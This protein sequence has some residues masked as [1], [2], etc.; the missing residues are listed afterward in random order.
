MGYIKFSHNWNNKLDC[1]IFTTIRDATDK[2][3]YFRSMQG[4]VVDILLNGKRY[5]R[6]KVKLV[7]YGDL[8]QIP[9]DVKVN[10]TGT[11]DYSEIFNKFIKPN[12]QG[13]Q[14]VFL[15]RLERLK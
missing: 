9:E 8:S 5:C 14:K 2:F 7:R 4:R 11:E 3:D 15:L 10:D 12:E 1:N 13:E 6:A